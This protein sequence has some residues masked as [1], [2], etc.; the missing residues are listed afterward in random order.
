MCQE[1]ASTVYVYRDYEKR[2]EC[3]E[4]REIYNKISDQFFNKYGFT[5]DFKEYLASTKRIL[6]K[7]LDC[8]LSENRAG[9][10]IVKLEEKE[11]DAKYSEKVKDSDYWGMVSSL[12]Q[13]I[14][15]QINTKEMSMDRFYSHL[16]IQI[17]KNK[18][19]AKW[20]RK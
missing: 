8:Y 14:G 1:N 7:K 19:L 10:T 5:D 13:S 4:S 18:E 9:L 20:Q 2:K 12:E 11:L 3:R 6:L 17:K 15:F 16:N